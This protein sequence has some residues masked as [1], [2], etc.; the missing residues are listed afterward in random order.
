MENP[1]VTPT[2]HKKGFGLLW[3]E[4]RKASWENGTMNKWAS[5]SSIIYAYFPHSLQVVF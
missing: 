5:I 3:E 4:I 1:S 2:A